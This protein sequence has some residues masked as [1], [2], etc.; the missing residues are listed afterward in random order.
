MRLAIDISPK[1]AATRSKPKAP[2]S[3]QLMAPTIIRTRAIQS[4]MPRVWAR[5]VA[6]LR[7]VVFMNISSGR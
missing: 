2:T 4:A 3:P 1:I 6:L 7:K 5:V